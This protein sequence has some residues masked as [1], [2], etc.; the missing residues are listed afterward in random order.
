ML[1]NGDDDDDN[2]GTIYHFYLHN[3]ILY[4]QKFEAMSK[5]E[6][7]NFSCHSNWELFI[8]LL[9]FIQQKHV[10]FIPNVRLGSRRCTYLQTCEYAIVQTIIFATQVFHKSI[11][12][13]NDPSSI[14]E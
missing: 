14:W 12:N 6:P 8:P 3:Y 13:L 9:P 10:E 5:P 1:H 2:E 11:V 4:Q 7:V